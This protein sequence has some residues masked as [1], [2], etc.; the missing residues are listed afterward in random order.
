MLQVT[1][2]ASIELKK[3]LEKNAD[4]GQLV[5][6]FQGMGWSGPALGMTLD[7]SIDEKVKMEANGITA[8]MDASLQGSLKQMASTIAIDFVSNPDGQSGFTIRAI[9]ENSDNCGSC[10]S[11]GGCSW[12]VEPAVDY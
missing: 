12:A 7:E 8:Y 11:S 9:G 4:K 6:F 1:D 5:I 2:T 10:A 3:V